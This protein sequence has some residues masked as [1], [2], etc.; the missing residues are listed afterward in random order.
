MSKAEKEEKT[1][2]YF[3]RTKIPYTMRQL[4][5]QLYKNCGISGMAIKGIVQGLVDENL[6]QKDKVGIQVLYWSFPSQ[7]FH[8]VPKE[9]VEF[10]HLI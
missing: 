9:K 4:E 8:T 5:M 2:A 1:I 7:A 3:H 6:I 10:L